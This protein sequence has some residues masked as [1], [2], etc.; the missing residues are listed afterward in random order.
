MPA[1][2]EAGFKETSAPVSGKIHPPLWDTLPYWFAIVS[3]V[4][5]VLVG[6][7]LAWLLGRY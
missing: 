7:L 1:F 6:L 2:S 5:G 4:I 3:P